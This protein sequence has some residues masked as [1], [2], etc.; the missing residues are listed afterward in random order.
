MDFAKSDLQENTEKSLVNALSNVKR[1][2][3]CRLASLLYI[4][5]YYQKTKRE[6]WNFP[7]TTDFLVKIGVVAPI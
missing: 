6:N 3:D 5:G 7:R 2:I 1:A 4:F